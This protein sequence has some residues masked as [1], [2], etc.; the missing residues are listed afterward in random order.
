ML[1]FGF[2]QDG[3]VGVGVFVE[4]RLLRKTNPAYK[5]L[6]AWIGAKRVKREIGL[7]EVKDIGGLFL[8]TLSPEI[9]MPYP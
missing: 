7:E 3:G 6:E 8:G 1:R 5:V 9:R 4:M 2:F